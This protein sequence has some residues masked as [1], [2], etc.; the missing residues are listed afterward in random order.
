MGYSYD[1]QIY[2]VFS[3]EMGRGEIR[4]IRVKTTIRK[5]RKR[6][7]SVVSNSLQPHGL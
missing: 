4:M 1:H 3:R 5:E 6:S 2:I 7:R